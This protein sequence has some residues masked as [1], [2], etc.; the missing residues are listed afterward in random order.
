MALSLASISTY[1]SIFQ[2]SSRGYGEYRHDDTPLEDGKKREGRAATRTGRLSEELYINHL[3]GKLGIGI[4]PIRED[5]T[6][7]F[8]VIDVDKYGVNHASLIN[9]IYKFS[10]PLAPFRSKSGGL[11]LYLLFSLAVEAKYAIGLANMYRRL[12]GLDK[13]T[14]IF[15]KQITLGEDSLGNWINAPYYNA[16]QTVQYL[17][18][19]NLKPVPFYEAM[20]WLSAHR[21]TP[22]SIKLINEAIPFSD[23]PPCLQAL[24]LLGVE[25]H[26]NN[27]LFDMAVYYK[28]KVGDDF[29][30]EVAAANSALAEPIPVT[31]LSD[32][33]IKS[34]KKKTYMY[35]CEEEPIVNICDKIECK[36]RKYGIG[37]SEIS[38]LSYGELI[39]YGLEDPYYEWKI[40][41]HPL[42]FYEPK[43]IMNQQT[44]R[45]KC[46]EHLH[47]FPTRLKDEA[48]TV[49][50]N[51]AL[52]NIIVKA[53]EEAEGF[54]VTDTFKTYLAEFLTKRAMAQSKAQILIGRVWYDPEA[55]SY[56]FRAANLM[57][58]LNK[59]KQFFSYSQAM[60]KDKLLGMKAAYIRMYLSKEHDGVRLWS[61]PKTSLDAFIEKP[62][63]DIAIDFMEKMEKEKY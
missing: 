59:Q 26:R 4:V 56:Y 22:D 30:Q 51:R 9:T 39:Q 11:H 32:T 24:R 54:S 34:H 57:E 13:K 46:F 47:I 5:G 18:A 63:D 49:V 27:Y 58:F 14:E 33:I 40:N 17:I 61:L 7:F 25:D 23:A 36:K 55:D 42:K 29:E 28:A 3:E 44:F 38:D 1:Q 62:S 21:Y 31:E 15:P 35:K 16:E 48:W 53:V 8:T 50:V 45:E 60:L 52:K 10:L 6:T 2:G 43:D 41:E 20:E 37:G 19:P 12:L